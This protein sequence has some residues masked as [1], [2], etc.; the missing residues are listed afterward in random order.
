MDELVRFLRDL[1]RTSDDWEIVEGTVHNFLKDDIKDLFITGIRSRLSSVP[2]IQNYPR[3]LTHM[4]GLL[5][6]LLENEVTFFEI[7]NLEIRDNKIRQKGIV[8]LS[9]LGNY[10]EFKD[11]KVAGG[12]NRRGTALSAHGWMSIYMFFQSGKSKAEGSKRITYEEI[13]DA[14][15][16][17]WEG[18]SKA[19]YWYWFSEPVGDDSFAYPG[20]QPQNLESLLT[21]LLKSHLDLIDFESENFE[22][23]ININQYV[24][25]YLVAIDEDKAEPDIMQYTVFNVRG[26]DVSSQEVTSKIN[27]GEWKTSQ[28]YERKLGDEIVE[29]RHLYRAKSGGFTGLYIKT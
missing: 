6:D 16:A 10:Q 17:F 4:L 14:R 8:N 21:R 26:R 22:V 29:V 1:D 28:P 13:M 15:M 18:I 25:D 5:G 20:Q 23:A 27:S 11:G 12:G 9:P 2:E 24:D 7:T 19:P 3:L